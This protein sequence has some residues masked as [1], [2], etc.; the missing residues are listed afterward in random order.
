MESR[1]DAQSMSSKHDRR[2]KRE[3]EPVLYN[4]GKKQPKP[5]PKLAARGTSRD[6][7]P[8]MPISLL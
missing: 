8:F 6:C 7:L 3:D 5:E 1:P 2:N 4:G